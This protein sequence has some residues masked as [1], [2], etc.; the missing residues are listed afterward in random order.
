MDRR[1]VIHKV[2]L[3]LGF[4]AILFVLLAAQSVH[5]Q[6]KEKKQYKWKMFSILG[7]GTAFH[8]TL[9]DW[10]AWVNRLSEGQIEIKVSVAGAIVGS[11][12][13]LDA[14]GKRILDMSLDTA[15]YWPGKDPTFAVM[16][17]LPCGFEKMEQL[18][19]WIYKRGGLEM[20][21][22]QYDKFNVYLLAP[23]Y[24]S[25]EYLVSRKPIRSVADFKGKKLVF[26][27][28]L[29]TELFTRLGASVVQMPTQE[30]MPA[31]ERGVIDGGDVGTPNTNV[32]YGV[33]RVAKYLIA[34]SVH[35][36]ATAL[37][38]LINKNLWSE[39]PSHLKNLLEAAATQI[40]WRCYRE[41]MEM[42][43]EAFKAMK[44]AGVEIITLPDSD[45]KQ[46][47]KTALSVW[48]DLGR[49]T[50]L[51]NKILDSQIALMK[52]FGLLE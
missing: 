19:F 6:A 25:A 43:A 39:L 31:L 29:P 45:I 27:G 7:Q 49:K 21:R 26:S 32:A 11:T 16:A 13:S 28:S 46:I 33:H 18:D 2:G 41:Y 5:A 51:S 38:L 36:P 24:Y 10:S 12:E 35:Q 8:K 50:P 14:V 48:N 9:V 17:Y 52:E 1:K 37:T 22:E 3:L 47:R 15:E 42:D 23:A 4:I 34:P 30:R 44:E 40:S 20:L